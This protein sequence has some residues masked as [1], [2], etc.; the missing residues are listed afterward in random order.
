MRTATEAS[1]GKRQLERKRT[2]FVA[3]EW[4]ALDND[5]DASLDCA[6]GELTA[7]VGP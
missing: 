5:D 3:S 4:L 7:A 6:K 1:M 2:A